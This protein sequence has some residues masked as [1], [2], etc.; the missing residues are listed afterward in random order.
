[1]SVPAAAAS[2]IGIVSDRRRLAAAAGRE[3]A[4]APAL[5]VAQLEAAADARVGFYQ[6]REPD[7]DGA[8]LLALA[9]RL[10]AVAGGRTRVVVNDRA[11]VA[12]LAGAGLHLKHRSIDAARL[13]PWM[14][15]ATWMSRAVHTRDDVLAAGPVDAVIAGTAAP[16]ASKMAGAPTL[17]AAGLAA[18]VAASDVPVFA[19]GGLT[20]SD[21]RWVAA[22]GAFGIAAIGA[23]LP[24]RGDDLAAATA[25][26]IAGFAAEID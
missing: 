8:T 23:F 25:R 18:I 20:P 17:G 10:V 15:R 13:R 9:R 24:R 21:W 1:V 11:D 12:A 2:R 22:S 6:L 4:D 5:L 26:A 3:L 19:I 14:P 7:L 16:S